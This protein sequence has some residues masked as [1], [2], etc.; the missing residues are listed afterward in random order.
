VIGFVGVVAGQVRAEGLPVLDRCQL[1]RRQPAQ[2]RHQLLLGAVEVGQ[3][4]LDLEG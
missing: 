3:Q 4:A 2:G 1:V